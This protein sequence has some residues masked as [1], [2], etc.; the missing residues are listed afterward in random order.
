MTRR[1][2]APFFP[3]PPREYSQAYFQRVIQDFATYIT[4]MDNPGEGRATTTVLTDVPTSTSNVEV[5]TVYEQATNLRIKSGTASEN[6]SGLPVPQFTNATLPAVEEGTIIYDSVPG[7]SYSKGLRVS[8]GVAWNYLPMPYET[9]TYDA[10]ITPNGSGS[11]T[12][13]TVSRALG[14]VRMGRFVHVQGQL[15]VSSVSSPSGTALISLPYLSASISDNAER[16]AGSVML[17]GINYGLDRTPHITINGPNL[18]YCQIL[19]PQSNT[20]WTTLDANTIGVG[21]DF[22]IGFS[23][24]TNEDT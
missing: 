2:P 9:G 22:R 17:Q 11:V 15:A 23:Y 4:R 12:L 16:L 3:I 5:G 8:D 24:M 21:D 19:M 7:G 10:T 20:T 13:S 14:Y 6:T 18:S 1:T